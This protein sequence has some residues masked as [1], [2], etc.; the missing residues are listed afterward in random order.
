MLLIY[1]PA[2]APRCEYVFEL[3]FR[4]ELD[5]QYQVTTDLEIFEAHEQEKINYSF[6]RN[7]QEYYI[8]ASS[9]LFGNGIKEI[10]ISAEKKFGTTVLFSNDTSC[11]LGF[12]I[13]SAVFYMVSRYEEYLPF[14]PDKY[15]R[16]KAS[17]SFAYRN[18]L[19]Q[20]PVVNTWINIFRKILVEKFSHL[21]LKSS[22]FNYIITYDIDIAYAFKGRSLARLI[23]STV[24][25]ILA[26]RFKNIF[27]R[28]RTVVNIQKDP[29]DVYDVMQDTIVEN[30]IHSIFFFLLA[31]YSRHDKNISYTHPLIKELI[32]RVST[33]SEIGIHPSFKSFVI[34]EKIQVEKKRLESLS[35]EKIHRSRQHYLRFSLP[36]TYN[37]LADAGIKEDYSMGFSDMPGFRAGTCKPFYFY[38]LKNERPTGLKL[39]PVTFMEGTFIDY[40]K[41]STGEALEYIFKLI[42]EVKNAEGTFISI[43]HNHTLS[44]TN[45]YKGWRYV[46]D[47]MIERILS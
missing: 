30:K 18:N 28:I 41:I 29:W 33:F 8:H 7:K 17:D 31:D 5:I 46:H 22:S 42:E 23:G 12:D 2:V 13:F 34:P 40:L 4:E 16:F 26:L 1:L 37:H 45:M 19:L 32:T 39:F 15:G 27:N 38:D 21:K 44:E 20:L 43:W 10:E 24:K 47:R 11:D 9:F 14:T 35:G 36:G 25:D 6:K 3:I